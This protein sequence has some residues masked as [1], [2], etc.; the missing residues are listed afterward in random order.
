MTLAVDRPEFWAR[1]EVTLVPGPQPTKSDVWIDEAA[2]VIAGWVRDETGR[3][4]IGATTTLVLNLPPGSSAAARAESRYRRVQSDAEGRYEIRDVRPRADLVL[5]ASAHGFTAETRRSVVVVADQESRLDFALAPDRV[6]RGRLRFRSGTRP[7]WVR[8]SAVVILDPKW[9]PGMPLSA[10][11]EY[12]GTHP[13]RVGDSGE[14][15]F[16]VEAH[17]AAITIV[18]SA[19]GL[20]PV[21]QQAA[22]GPRASPTPE[23]ELV[24]D[25]PG[26]AVS[27][28]VVDASGEAVRATIEFHDPEAQVSHAIVSTDAAGRFS[29]GGLAPLRYSLRVKE[30]D[31]GRGRSTILRDVEPDQVE[32]RI[33]L[34]DRD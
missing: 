7:A 8:V 5:G 13:T 32:L 2:G 21:T 19:D 29:C 10:A 24:L 14:F 9:L 16:P 11:A 15:E 33:V 17:A 1:S 3:P 4:I 28:V 25:S 6:V 20:L 12:Y 31:D 18:A 26:R 30:L 27:G 34:A 23:L 22:L